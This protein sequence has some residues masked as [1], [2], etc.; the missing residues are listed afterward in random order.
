MITNAEITLYHYD[1][2][3]ETWTKNSYCPV[4]VYTD[5]LVSV[6]DTGLSSADVVKIRIPTQQEVPIHNG[7]RV[8]RGVSTAA[9]PD[10]DH[11]FTVISWSDNRRG[12][13]PHYRVTCR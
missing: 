2:D 12:T 4:H 7:D 5:N 9:S 3:E 6:D 10:R 11:G 1:E 8:V 13:A